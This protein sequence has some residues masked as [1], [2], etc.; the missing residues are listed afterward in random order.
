[1]DLGCMHQAKKY[2]AES[3][4]LPIEDYV[5]KR[6]DTVAEFARE[7][8]LLIPPSQEMIRAPIRRN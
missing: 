1:M 4:L 2:F 5:Q 3:G 6:K 7:R 8:P